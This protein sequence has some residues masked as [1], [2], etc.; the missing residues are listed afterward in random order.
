MNAIFA[1][2]DEEI[3]LLRIPLEVDTTIHL[4]PGIIWHGKLRGH[5]VCLVR[6]GPGE[7]AV[8]TAAEYCFQAFQPEDALLLGYG[9][10][11]VPTFHEGDLVVSESIVPTQG[12][13][14]MTPSAALLEAARTVCRVA[15]IPIHGGTFAIHE[16]ILHSPHEKAFLGTKCGAAVV[17]MEGIT[18]ARAAEAHNIPWLSVR[19]IFDPMEVALP[20]DFAPVTAEGTMAWGAFLSYC[21]RNPRVITR[22]SQFHFAAA[23]AREQ[24]ERFAK[25]WL[26]R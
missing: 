24:L 12:D 4:K 7:E 15:E 22:L 8:Q 19:S 9:G 1:P 3:K 16:D 5:E 26:G 23:K 14:V 18:F 13:D 25:A 21:V 6:T 17:A 2:L 20:E 11:T 10:A